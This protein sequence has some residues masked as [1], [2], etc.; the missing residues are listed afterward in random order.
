MVLPPPVAPATAPPPTMLAPAPSPSVSASGVSPTPGPVA[1]PGFAGILLDPEPLS[2][3]PTELSRSR[4]A[5][6]SESAS[7]SVETPTAKTSGT[8]PVADDLVLPRAVVRF[9]SLASLLGTIGAFVA[10]LL[11]GHFLWR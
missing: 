3:R 2:I 6:P 5:R 4:P 9:W 10:G 7:E 8:I 11:V 1:E